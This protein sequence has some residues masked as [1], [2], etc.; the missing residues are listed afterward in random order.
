V[1]SVLEL[2]WYLTKQQEKESHKSTLFLSFHPMVLAGFR[3]NRAVAR[4]LGETSK[5]ARH[6]SYS[7]HLSD[8]MYQLH[9]LSLP[10]LE[11][12]D[13]RHVTGAELNGAIR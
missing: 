3:Q 5:T 10:I 8:H 12:I 6:N 1:R 11:G 7:E 2:A 9:M 4:T 13:C